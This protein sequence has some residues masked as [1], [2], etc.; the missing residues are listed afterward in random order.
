[1]LRMLDRLVV[2]ITARGGVQEVGMRRTWKIALIAALLGAGVSLDP[3]LHPADVHLG[4]AH[5]ASRADAP[6]QACT[7]VTSLE[8]VHRV[9]GAPVTATVRLEPGAAADPD[10]A[11]RSFQRVADYFGPETIVSSRPLTEVY[12]FPADSE[13]DP[14]TEE[15]P[16]SQ[17]QAAVLSVDGLCAN[18]FGQL[19][20]PLLTPDQRYDYSDGGSCSVS[21]FGEAK[22]YACDDSGVIVSRRGDVVLTVNTETI[23][24]EVLAQTQ[25]LQRLMGDANVLTNFHFNIVI[26]PNQQ[27]ALVGNQA[28]NSLAQQV[29]Q[30]S[31]LGQPLPDIQA[32]LRA[33]PQQPTNVAFFEQL[34]KAYQTRQERLELL[35]TIT[36]GARLS[37]QQVNAFYQDF[38]GKSQLVD[39]LLVER[40]APS[41]Q[42]AAGVLNDIIAQLA[43]A[44]PLSTIYEE[45][46]A[47]ARAVL[48]T[49]TNS[50][51]FDPDHVVQVVP[52]LYQF[53]TDADLEKRLV[54][55]ERL[56]EFNELLRKRSP[57][58]ELIEAAGG[59]LGLL[60]RFMD[61][62]DMDKVYR[63][64]DQVEAMEFFAEGG[65]PR[66]TRYDVHLSNDARTMFDIDV[67]P[68]SAATYD[69]T[70]LLN[71]VADYNRQTGQ[72]SVDYQAIIQLN[73]RE[74]LPPADALRALYHTEEASRWFDI[75]KGF[76]GGV[77]T[78]FA[79]AASD[80]VHMATH[81]FETI[82]GLKAAIVNWDQ[83]LALVWREGAE[84]IHRWP[85]MTAEEK[86]HFMGRLAAQIVTELP[87]KMRQ[88]GRVEDAAREAVRIHLDKANL[89]LRIVERG[90]VA[91]APEAASELARRMEQLGVTALDDMV[92]LSDKLDDYL[93]C[94][95]VGG[96]ALQR[97]STAAVKPPC[98]ATQISALINDLWQQAR[99]LG[100]K[101]PAQ[102]ADFIAAAAK[103][104][105]RKIGPNL[106]ESGAGLRYSRDA[107]D[108]EFPHRVLHVLDHGV[109]HPLWAGDHGVFD[110]G[111]RGALRVV[112]EGWRRVTENSLTPTIQ[113]GNHRYE[114]P[115]GRRIGFVGGRGG[116]AAGH[117]EA[118]YLVIVVKPNGQH[119]IVTA[120]PFRKP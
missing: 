30:A 84:L 24:Q 14:E 112:D 11:L 40:S 97:I 50:C 83:T 37:P 95:L 98:G 115:M 64:Y 62:D 46:K 87:S 22:S 39:R 16:P 48:E 103:S 85:D 67:A 89:G 56:I 101:E 51:V 77:L 90:G 69:V 54:A 57:S 3:G 93:P 75:A 58:V 7:A 76:A 8:I 80:I 63:V 59:L 20:C 109:D 45:V 96:A 38:V 44:D 13:R 18:E 100:L 108:L 35:A 19:P 119:D 72:I 105:L 33:L 79:D 25:A 111:R 102:I 68:T 104:G 106:W 34:K 28:F 32:L 53:L 12:C 82:E 118:T 41:L 65:D 2:S 5:G 23:R 10:R 86:A 120:F 74:A 31:E 92:E 70:V 17:T 107:A 113:N 42:R 47:A 26:S 15:A 88:A 43:S 99:S 78:E 91:L 6:A 71:K 81:P 116:T 55:A 117:P 21:D 49:H 114:I 36:N 29:R 94:R 27:A 66:G 4:V 52:P 73:A 9:G 60:T 61:N 110:A 1:M